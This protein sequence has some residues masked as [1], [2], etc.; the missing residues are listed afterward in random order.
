MIFIYSVF[1]LLLFRLLN[2]FGSFF[3]YTSS[4][5]TKVNKL[6]RGRN[7][8]QCNKLKSLVKSINQNICRFNLFED[9]FLIC[10]YIMIYILRCLFSHSEVINFGVF[11]AMFQVDCIRGC[12]RLVIRII[13]R[14][15]VSA[16]LPNDKCVSCGRF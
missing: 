6:L 16:V 15:T 14:Y 4:F 3:F 11:F 5:C 7:S 9:V 12:R 13:S 10:Y 1:F 2:N 8:A